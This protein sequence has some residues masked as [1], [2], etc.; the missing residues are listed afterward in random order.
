VAADLKRIGVETERGSNRITARTVRGWCEEVSE[1]F[2]R[3]CE[4]GS[5]AAEAVDKVSG[6]GDLN[7]GRFQ[8]AHDPPKA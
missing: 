2:G 3:H 6:V 8:L 7:G 5:D 4:F 1:N